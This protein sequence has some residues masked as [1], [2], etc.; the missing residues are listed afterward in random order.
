MFAFKSEKYYDFEDNISDDTTLARELSPLKAIK[1]S[2]PKI[3]LANTRH[4]SYDIDGIR[5]IDIA[6]WLL[7]ANTPF[8]L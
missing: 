5:V 7:E 3:L 8:S 6:Q 2:Y 1:D 4:D